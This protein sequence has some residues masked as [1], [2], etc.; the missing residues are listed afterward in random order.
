[1]KRKPE[2]KIPQADRKFS[3]HFDAGE[4]LE[5]DGPPVT[6]SGQ[7]SE[8]APSAV[9]MVTMHIAGSVL[10]RFWDDEAKSLSSP[11][12]LA[13]GQAARKTEARNV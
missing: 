7:Y 4:W 8:R 3:E 2:N 9:G 6:V 1:M 13:N 5:W 10:A 11:F 12:V